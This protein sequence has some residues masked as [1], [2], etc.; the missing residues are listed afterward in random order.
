MMSEKNDFKQNFPYGAMFCPTEV[1]ILDL[2]L[3]GEQIFCQRQ[4]VQ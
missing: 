3:T 1:A 2:Q 4:M